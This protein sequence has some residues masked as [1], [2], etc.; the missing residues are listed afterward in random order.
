MKIFFMG[1]ERTIDSDKPEDLKGMM[2]EPIKNMLATKNEFTIDEAGTIT[3]VNGTDKKKGGD[4]GMA[5]MFMQQMN[6]AAALLKPGA[7]SFFRFLPA[8]EVGKGDSWT[9]TMSA[10]GIVGTTTYTVKDIT[11]TDVFLDYAGTGKIDTKREMMGMSMDVK[12][13]LKSSGTVTLDKATGIVKQKTDTTSTES[14][15][16]MNGQELNVKARVT[17][18]T[19]VRTL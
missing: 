9:D 13:T 8:R 12:G 7:P 3:A 10:E 2:G 18:V 19:N 16:N 4:N 5:G 1:Q 15:T 6:P 17:S 11:A 14:T